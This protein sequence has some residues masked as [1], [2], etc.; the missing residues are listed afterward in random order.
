GERDA[1][2]RREFLGTRRGHAPETPE[3]SQQ[4]APPTWPDSR[5]VVERRSKAGPRPQLLMVRVGEAVRLVS[6]A[7]QQ[8]ERRRVRLQNAGIPPSPPDHP[9][10]PSQDLAGR[11]V[12][13][14]APLGQPDDLEIA[15]PELLEHAASRAQL[16]QAAVD[17]EEI[18]HAAAFAGI[19]EPPS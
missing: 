2:H 18:R 12:A 3:A 1:R 15:E 4:S 13:L 16:T 17:Y 6:H 10:R 9:L 11:R 19:A 7:L 8:E 14:D 5:N